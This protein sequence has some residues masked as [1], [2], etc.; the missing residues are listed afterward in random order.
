MQNII[1][2]H[3][4]IVIP[5][6]LIQGTSFEN[7]EDITIEKKNIGLVI[8]TNKDKAK[9]LDEFAELCEF[10]DKNSK[11]DITMKEACELPNNINL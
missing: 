7:E 4:Q 3:D 9:L 6:D 2:N 5:L 10:I 8:S 1:I 11:L